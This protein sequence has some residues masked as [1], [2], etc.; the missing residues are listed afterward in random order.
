MMAQRQ[1]PAGVA[2][3]PQRRRWLGL[4]LGVAALA[5]SPWFARAQTPV[6]QRVVTLGGSITEIAYALGQGTRLVAVDSSSLYP[7]EADG[8]P[9]IGYY[10]AAPLE[11]ILSLGPDLVL[12]SEQAGPADVLQRLQA[13]GVR[14]ERVS[15]AP[16]LGSL[17]RR[18]EQVAQALG[19]QQQGLALAQRVRAELDRA[20]AQPAPALRAMVLVNR[21]GAL[22]AAGEATAAG[23]TLA[24]AGLR[25]VMSGQRGYKPVSPEGMAALQPELIVVTSASAE[26][27]GGI[28]AIRRRA[29]V[30]L[31]P[32]ARSDRIVAVDD[33]L[34]LGL[35]PRVAEAV[36]ILK[37]AAG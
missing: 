1:T 6:P 18:I 24:L 32:A 10:R 14:L 15:D 26:A 4:G 25:N 30:A 5:A 8:L 3:D 35:G 36:A 21:T 7:P 2:A 34:I 31:T 19:A 11:G 17:F 23:A 29:G 28:G 16:E 9:R 37:Q 12:A 33:L 13:L 27:S 20:Q 22:M